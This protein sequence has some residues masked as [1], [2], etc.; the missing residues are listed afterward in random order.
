MGLPLDDHLHLGEPS[1]NELTNGHA[2]LA[3]L[4]LHNAHDEVVRLDY[5]H[6]VDVGDKLL[7]EDIAVG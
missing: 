4:R 1:L 2:A 7:E 6:S 5:Q 3:E